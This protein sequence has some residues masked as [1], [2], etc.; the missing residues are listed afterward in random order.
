MT[1]ESELHGLRAAPVRIA[2]G[3]LS[4]GTALWAGLVVAVPVA[5]L[6][7]ILLLPVPPVIGV[8]IV[9]FLAFVFWANGG[10]YNRKRTTVDPA[11]GT[12]SIE[13]PSGIDGRKADVHDL[14]AVEAVA[15][16]RLGRVGLVTI[17][18]EASLMTASR[19]V[20]PATDLPAVTK[21]IRSTGVPVVGSEVGLFGDGADGA[22]RTEI[23]SA[24][25]ANT[26]GPRTRLVA[27]ALLLL[28]IPVVILVAFGSGPVALG[29]AWVLMVGGIAVIGGGLLRFLAGG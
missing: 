8:Q 19:F 29:A 5:L 16:Q 24:S 15:I 13:R 1:V 27:T 2:L 12:V 3:V 4:I 7:G 28:G 18:S 6:V 10:G 11:A 20:A 9:L 22:D 26:P 14:E 23:E 21:A 25:D 17:W